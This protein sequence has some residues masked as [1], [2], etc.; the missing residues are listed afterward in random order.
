[1]PED[2][3]QVPYSFRYMS[4]K[5]KPE[6]RDW[7][8]YL[9]CAG[10]HLVGSQGFSMFLPFLSSSVYILRVQRVQTCCVFSLQVCASCCVVALEPP[11]SSSSGPPWEHRE[12]RWLSSWRQDL[13]CHVPHLSE[14]LAKKMSCSRPIS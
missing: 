14:A 2:T 4:G 12:L 11:C 6:Y 7:S 10:L 8:F 1:M 9:I 5:H 13:R 3:F